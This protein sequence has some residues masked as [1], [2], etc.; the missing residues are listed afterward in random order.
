MTYVEWQRVWRT[1]KIAAIVLI[2][3]EI[4]LLVLRIS[5]LAVGPKNSLSFAHGIEMQ[6]GSRVTHSLVQGGV[7][8]TVID[9][10][11]EGVRI[12]IDD[13]GYQ[14]KHI[15]IVESA[16]RSSRHPLETYAMGDLHVDTHPEGNQT[17]TTIDTGKPEDL[18]YYIAIATV[19]GLIIATCLGAPFARENDG[20]LEIALTKPIGRER[21]AVATIGADLVGI[22]AVWLMAIFFLVIG[23]TI[24]EVP[25]YV[26][27][28]YDGAGL[29]LG[30]LGCVAWYGL[31]CAATA[32]MRRGYGAVLGFMWPVATIVALLGQIDLSRSVLGQIVHAI[33]TPLAWI[34]PVS[35]LHF[36]TAVTIN[37]RPAGSIAAIPAGSVTMLA[38]LAIVYLMLAVLQWRRVEA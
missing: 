29:A 2:V 19:V 24:F 31:L 22:V 34:D 15:E 10:A 9:N 8:R 20:H 4:L 37:D 25:H 6:P 26:F 38:V 33:V 13:R 16:A 18:G 21:L 5:L 28:P 11:S 3:L 14:G 36:G 27:G 12:V 23:H 1:L 32:S 30:L 35:Y 17:V 7:T